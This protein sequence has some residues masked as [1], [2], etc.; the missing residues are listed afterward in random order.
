MKLNPFLQEGIIILEEGFFGRKLLALKVLFLLT[1][2]FAAFPSE[3]L[4]FYLQLRTP[5]S[6]VYTIFI[7]YFV[8]ALVVYITLMGRISI[9][10]EKITYWLNY[11]DLPPLKLIAGKSLLPLFFL[12]VLG[13]AGFPFLIFSARINAVSLNA[14]FTAW[15][16]SLLIIY[17]YGLLSSL[18]T[19]LIER[20]PLTQVVIIW[21]IA[22]FQVL[23]SYKMLPGINP[24]LAFSGILDGAGK[25]PPELEVP[26][27]AVISVLG[28]ITAFVL[29]CISSHIKRRNR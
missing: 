17:F 29:I 20:S 21:L 3:P 4:A 9:R 28:I 8:C 7:L 26:S 5:P 13:I 15:I 12:M 18:L 1:V 24:L 11:T 10:S 27:I 23:F 14:V 22:F 6:Y 16:I 25:S 19:L 2:S